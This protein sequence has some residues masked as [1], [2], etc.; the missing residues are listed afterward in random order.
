MLKTLKQ[1][2]IGEKGQES[3][4]DGGYLDLSTMHIQV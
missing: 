3:V 4:V 1:H 2:R